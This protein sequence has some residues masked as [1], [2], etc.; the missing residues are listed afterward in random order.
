MEV[1]NNHLILGG[2]PVAALIAAFGSP[3]Y[4]YEEDVLRMRA[5][6]IEGAISY[7][8]KEIKFAC[9]ANTNI[10]IMRI[11]REEGMGIDAVSPG[12]IYAALN[13]GYSPSQVLFTISNATADDIKYA[14]SKEVMVNIDS[15]SQLHGFGEKHPGSEICIRIN[16]DIGAGHHDHV[17]TG[18]PESKFGIHYAKVP[19]IKRTA[20]EFDLAIKGVHQHIGSGILQPEKFIEAMDVLLHVAGRFDSLS[21]IDFGGGIGVP[22]REDEER[23]DMEVL[24]TSITDEFS[25]FCKEYGKELKLVIEPGRYLVAECGFL[26]ATVTAV[27]EGAKHR[28]VGINTG[29]NHLVR[30]AMYGSYH[31]IIN[32][33][34]V[35]GK[36]VPQVIAGN[37]CES[38]DIFTRD[39]EGIVD[40]DLPL[41]KEGDAVCIG[42]A[43]AYGYSMASN[44]CSRTRPS[45]VLVQKGTT[46]LIRRCE[47][48]EEI[49]H[50]QMTVPE[51][52]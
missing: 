46:R 24:G 22:Y 18:G 38:G 48:I 9:K 4:V 30:P 19:E 20:H 52:M 43:G 51:R 25:S 5:R 11:L 49:F 6:E 41:F 27:K 45:E 44:Y 50:T 39:E 35:E 14:V 15:L 47:T 1:K 16:P 42:N 32:G 36:K 3:L 34:S 31:P 12:E 33:T 26:L 8:N 17:I 23:I 21:F 40:R 2:V 29:F 37:L 10:E 28:F 13:A 7:Q